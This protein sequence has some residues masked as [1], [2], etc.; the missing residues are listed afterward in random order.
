MGYLPFALSCRLRRLCCAFL[1]I[2]LFCLALSPCL[3]NGEP[4]AA[5]D[6][7]SRLEALLQA[8]A[9]QDGSI[10]TDVSEDDSAS[11][12]FAAFLGKGLFGDEDPYTAWEQISTKPLVKARGVCAGD[13]LCTPSHTAL[14]FTATEAGEI[15]TVECSDEDGTIRIGGFFLG[16][17]ESATF[18]DICTKYGFTCLLHA[19]ENASPVLW[20]RRIESL[21]EGPVITG[22]TYPTF[23]SNNQFFGLRGTVSCKYLITKIQAT[24]T[25]RVTLETIFDISVY[26]D[27]YTYVIGRPVTETINDSLVF[28]SP[29]CANSYLNYTLTV[30]YEKGGETL[31]ESVLSRDFQVGMPLVKEPSA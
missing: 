7:S 10:W 15:R 30:F 11:A 2:T 22:A 27:A 23:L 24:V 25:N 31:S 26:P 3:A 29:E 8:S 13:I 21:L 6:V 9:L 12:A 28:N 20:S 16:D 4:P 5:E 17:T 14:I 19:G 18:E 1:L